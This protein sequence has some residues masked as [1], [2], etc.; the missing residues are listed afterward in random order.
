[1]VGTGSGEE[2]RGERGKEGRKGGRSAPQYSKLIDASEQDVPQ[3]NTNRSTLNCTRL[4]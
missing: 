3:F 1:M 2:G 4:A